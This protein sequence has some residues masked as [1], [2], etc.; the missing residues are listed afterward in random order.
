MA[1]LPPRE[2]RLGAFPGDLEVDGFDPL[3]LLLEAGRLDPEYGVLPL[4]WPLPL[5]K[6]DLEVENRLSGNL[7]VL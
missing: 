7:T 4:D 3:K 5:E 6:A 2:G 1:P